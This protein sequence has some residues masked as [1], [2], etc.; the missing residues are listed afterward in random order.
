MQPFRDSRVLGRSRV[1]EGP[2]EPKYTL[3]ARL[4]QGG[5]GWGEP[6]HC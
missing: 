6:P 5:G 3:L 1:T 2:A 4:G